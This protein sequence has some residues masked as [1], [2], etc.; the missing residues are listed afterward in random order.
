MISLLRHDDSVHREDD[1]AA[2]FDDIMKKHQGKVRWYFAM[3]NQRLDNLSAKGRRT[4]EKIS[5][6]IEP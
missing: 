5:L 1:G 4:K 3:V 2:R 6:L